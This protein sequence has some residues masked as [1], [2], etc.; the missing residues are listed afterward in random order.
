MN[1]RDRVFVH[2]GVVGW[3]GRAILLPGRSM[4]G[5]STLVRALLAAG[6]TYYSDEFAVLD[7]KGRVHPFPRRLSLR[8]PGMLSDRPHAADLGAATGSRPL[9]V[10]L[11]VHTEYRPGAGWRPK[12][13][14]AAR[15][16][17]ELA[18]YM[19]PQ[20]SHS[21]RGKMVLERLATSATAL[22]GRRGDAAD[23]ANEIL[24]AAE[25]TRVAS[26]WRLL[27]ARAA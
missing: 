19:G 11:I 1:A 17:F 4:A 24:H 13:L 22:Y 27:F 10:G 7:A 25:R 8:R 16:M 18:S 15:S 20:V 6:A 2:A 14:T 3:Q 12:P 26:P 23:A 9:P 21:S 5:K